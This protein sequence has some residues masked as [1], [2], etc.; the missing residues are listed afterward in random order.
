MM[1]KRM[2]V[3]ILFVFVLTQAGAA[4]DAC[5]RH[6]E[7]S[8]AFSFCPPDGWSLMEKEGYKYKILHGPRGQVFTP[9]INI[10]DEANGAPL[11]DYVSASVKEI[12]TNYEKIGATSVKLLEQSNFATTKRTA[13]IRNAFRTEYKGL[14][15]RTLQ[16]YFNGKDGHKLIVTC[17]SLEEEKAT[18]DPIFDR[19][20]KSFQFDR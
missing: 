18:L 1:M 10:R 9:N 3:A 7:P 11:A 14:M 19:T 4:Q 16:Y 15:I 12:L 17:T 6:L 13:G 8:G 2:L 5:K 20:L